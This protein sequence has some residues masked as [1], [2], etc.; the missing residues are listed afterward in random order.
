MRLPDKLERKLPDEQHTSLTEIYAS[1][2][3]TCQNYLVNKGMAS[4]EDA[5]DIYA[6]AILILRKKI[7]GNKLKANSNLKSYLLGICMNLARSKYREEQKNNSKEAEVRNLLYET[8]NADYRKESQEV[9]NLCIQALDS[10]EPKGRRILELFYFENYTMKQIANELGYASS[11][12][13]KTAKYRVYKKWMKEA[14]KLRRNYFESN[15]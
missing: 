11:D 8:N 3:H 5:K 14:N 13:A 4:V 15:R 1:Q 10:I 2:F 12:A 9:L 6:D 7:I